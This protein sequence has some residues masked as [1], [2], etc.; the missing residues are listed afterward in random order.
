MGVIP[1]SKNRKSPGA[2]PLRGDQTSLRLYDS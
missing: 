2:M 1:K